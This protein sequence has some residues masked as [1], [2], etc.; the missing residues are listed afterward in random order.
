M[1]YQTGEAL[2]MKNI[3]NLQ[4]DYKAKYKV[5]KNLKNTIEEQRLLAS[6]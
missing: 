4:P 3:M 2:S 1:K 6:N 5:I